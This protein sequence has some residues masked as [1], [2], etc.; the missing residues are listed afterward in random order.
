MNTD[1]KVSAVATSSS[2]LKSADTLKVRR[3]E[4]WAARFAFLMAGFSIAAWAPIVPFIKEGLGLT[5]LELSRVILMMSAGSLLGMLLTGLAMRTFSVRAV[6]VSAA[7]ALALSLVAFTTLPGVSALSGL[8]FIFGLT[9]GC[10]EVGGN[11]YGA[12]LEKRYAIPLLPSLHGCY[13]LGEIV[14]LA[15]ITV[16]LL[17]NLTLLMAIFLPLLALLVFTV[18]SLSRVHVH[19][20]ESADEPLLAIPR[21]TVILIALTAA[22][23]Y[24]VE[25]GMLD[26]SALFMIESHGLS[27]DVAG[28]GYIVVVIAMAL[29]RFSG[30]RLVTRFGIFPVLCT[31][32]GLGALALAFLSFKPQLPLMYLTFAVLGFSIA[33]VMPL[34]I[35]LAARE[36][37]MSA[38]AAISAVSTAGYVALILGPALI[39]TV[40]EFSSLS[41]SFISLS[42]LVLCLIPGIFYVRRR[43]I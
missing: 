28:S 5:H 23:V 18:L 19:D 13:S 20:V 39:G 2:S 15:A 14:A 29:G 33:N 21:G 34:C 30:A 22:L 38:T 7:A 37:S 10:L 27:K 4:I 25:G 43:F 9:L 16:L 36:G 31:S 41:F 32:V 12:Y 35:S 6:L 17:M 1:I 8:V 26:W 24:M 11:L 3:L 40:A 42:V